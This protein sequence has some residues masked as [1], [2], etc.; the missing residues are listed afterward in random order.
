[1]ALPEAT[2]MM[3]ALALEADTVTSVPEASSKD[4]DMA[5]KSSAS[6]PTVI[7]AS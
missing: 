7:S 4:R 1:M 5:L 3:A 6:C 2:S